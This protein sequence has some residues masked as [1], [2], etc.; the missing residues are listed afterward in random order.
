MKIRDMEM[1]VRVAETGSMTVAAQQLNRT[2]AAVSGAIQRMEGALGMRLFER[3]TRSLRPTEEGQVLIEGCLELTQQWRRLLEDARGQRAGLAGTVHLSAPT[4]TSH[5]I[6]RPLLARLCEQHPQL[7]VQMDISDAIHHVHRDAIDI[8][9]RYGALQDSTLSARKL[10]DLPMILVAA[11]TYLAAHG[12]PA[13][14]EDLARHRCITLKMGDVPSI[15][16]V[17]YHN[18]ERWVVPI[19]SPLCG[20]GFMARQL[21]IDGWGITLKSLFD[22]IDDLEAGRLEPVLP[23]YTG[24]ML[25]IHAVF[26]S[27]R[28]M[29]ARVRALA[30]AI[31][32][33]FDARAQRCLAWRPP[34]SDL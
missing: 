6:L 1:L 11:P 25:P 7:R 3:T 27:R 9:I 19:E 32:A 21:A 26:P 12:R 31:T 5:Q 8:A 23:T 24:E 4:D 20:D 16:W 22:V 15:S 33:A 10:V 30:T 34:R 17:L 13:T 29:P 2:P 28:Y 18:G 14:L